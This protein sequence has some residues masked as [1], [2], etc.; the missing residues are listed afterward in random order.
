M[1]ISVKDLEPISVGKL[2]EDSEIEL[3]AGPRM[4]TAEQ[5][6]TLELVVIDEG[7]RYEEMLEVAGRVAGREISEIG[8]L[9]WEEI[10]R[11]IEI[12]KRETSRV[13]V[14]ERL[15]L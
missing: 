7:L 3:L 1:K 11:V 15:G 9:T 14:E 4:C 12:C 10:E 2:L 13:I 8:K 6:M 5:R